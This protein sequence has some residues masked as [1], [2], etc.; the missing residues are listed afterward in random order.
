[1]SERD[2]Y[3]EDSFKAYKSRLIQQRNNTNSQFERDVL[4]KAI[5]NLPKSYAEG[6]SKYTNSP[7]KSRKKPILKCSIIF[8]VSSFTAI[9]ALA[10]AVDCWEEW[11][12]VVSLILFLASVIVGIISLI[13]L[14][15]AII[16]K[17]KQSIRY[18][19][20]CY[21]KIDRIHSYLDRGSITEEEFD[22]LK[23]DI[24]NKI[25]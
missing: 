1:M 13:G 4:D 12:S 6:L 22:S 23:Q 5:A 10:W 16:L 9:E 7:T 11:E 21:K 25:G 14:I 24:L 20:K 3:D 19:E 2:F 8:A 17:Y 15:N 18:K